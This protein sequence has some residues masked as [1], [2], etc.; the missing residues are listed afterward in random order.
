MP[1]ED[2]EVLL[3]SLASLLEPDVP[4]QLDLLNAL[5]DCDGDV[6]AA[7][8]FLLTSR[9]PQQTRT[10]SKKRKRVDSGLEG[11]LRSA[12]NSPDVKR[13]NGPAR[14]E[15]SDGA[16]SHGRIKSPSKPARSQEGKGKSNEERSLKPRS[17]DI[18]ESVRP[19]NLMSILRA[20]P[21][22]K[23]NVYRNPPLT[24]ANPAM[25]A[26]YTPCTLHYSIL[27]HELAC[28]LFYT[29]L[30][31]A[32]G[33]SRN[34]W[35][36]FDR[37]VESPH[38]TSFFT[39]L[40]GFGVEGDPGET[41]R[42]AAQYWYNGRK[43]GPPS[44]FPEEMEEACKFVETVVNDELKKRARFPLE[45]GGSS[46]SDGYMWRANVAAANCYEG[47]K[48]TVGFHSDQLTY[49]GPYPTI[50]SLSLGTTRLFRLREVIP[51][52]ETS[53]RHAQTFNIP[54]PHNS[55]IIMHA[56]TQERFKHCVPPQP[57][58]DVFRPPFPRRSA[59]G[60][61]SITSSTEEIPSSNCRINITFRF[62]RPDFAPSTIPRCK[63]GVP[64]V[65]HPDMKKRVDHQDTSLNGPRDNKECP[66]GKRRWKSLEVDNRPQIKY[67]WNCYSGAQ[68][69]GKGCGMWKVMDVKTEGRGPFI[70]DLVSLKD[71]K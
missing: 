48:E 14:P 36:L 31:A 13:V 5:V 11:W 51:T 19:V 70:G 35:W 32:Q 57:V 6:E 42:E 54:L 40:E 66:E 61:S 59:P 21:A 39:R 65:L 27:P 71:V 43:T 18:S 26:E 7:A 45:W 9:H 60:T 62:Y 4:K 68:N 63:C 47:A 58:I 46:G 34:K 23:I 49:L 22:E 12:S 56:S 44:H 2:T 52:S 8:R 50:A 55:L 3:A 30:D 15:D 41:W 33:W 53:E 28:E 64:C 69:E 25:V 29:M 1:S 38:R 20:P 16:S 24:L 67:W 10:D 17:G 37:L